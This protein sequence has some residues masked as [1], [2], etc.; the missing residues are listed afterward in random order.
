MPAESTPGQVNRSTPVPTRGERS[1]QILGISN[2]LFSTKGYSATTIH[3][4]ADL[5][6]VLPGS[7][8]HHF[9]SKAAIAVALLDGFQSDLK[10]LVSRIRREEQNDDPVER[11]RHLT[12]SVARVSVQH[13]AAVRMRAYEAPPV[14][15]QQ[16]SAALRTRTHSLTSLWR[17]QMRAISPLTH[18]EDLDLTLLRFAF[19][20][21]SLN[22]GRLSDTPVEFADQI[23]DSLL[24]GVFTDEVWDQACDSSPAHD[25]VRD[26]LQKWAELRREQVSD[27]RSLIIETARKQ[28]ALY[29]Y[30]ATTIRDIASA[31]DIPMG[32]LYRR[33]ESKEALLDEVLT[34][35]SDALD[36][37]INAALAT[38]GATVPESIDALC[39]LIVNAARIWKYDDHIARFEWFQ[40]GDASVR[41][42]EQGTVRRLAM[43]IQTIQRGQEDGSIK[44]ELPASTLA[45]LMR[46]IFWLPFQDHHH[47]SKAGTLSLLRNSVLGGALR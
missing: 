42:F 35:Y 15:S 25:A 3:D 16:M 14:D 21:L 2:D 11:V 24:Y 34:T 23:T 30:N 6:G 22:A 4:I 10:S 47:T 39:V 44:A 41:V 40:Q 46:K 31:A 28:F 8:Y 26:V 17:D 38:P 29:G 43:F 1:A 9:D 37:G 5:A 45:P 13:R 18:R 32:S 7:L 36:L 19:Q 12:R 27:E 33:I 20:Y